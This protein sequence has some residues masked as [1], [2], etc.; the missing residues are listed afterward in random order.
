MDQSAGLTSGSASET[1]DGHATPPDPSVD[2]QFRRIDDD[3]IQLSHPPPRLKAAAA[4]DA[5]RESRPPGGLING[6]KYKR[7]NI[8]WHRDS[9]ASAPTR[10]ESDPQLQQQRPHADALAT[11]DQHPTWPSQDPEPSSSSRASSFSVDRAATAQRLATGFV[12]TRPSPRLPQSSPPRPPIAGS[13]TSAAAVGSSYL[14]PPSGPSWSSA[15][16]AATTTTRPI[17]EPSSSTSTLPYPTRR[18]TTGTSISTALPTRALQPQRTLS[19]GPVTS[20]PPHLV[21]NV[22]HEFQT[23]GGLGG[24]DAFQDSIAKQ[25]HAIRKEREAKKKERARSGSAA[26]VADGVL[27]GNLVGEDHVNYVLMYNMLTGIR[28]GVRF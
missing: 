13:S 27:V 14:Q 16:A 3:A 28:I 19:H 25:A 11:L 7:D 5:R 23:D 4:A 8:D 24:D 18:N 15:A 17:S 26:G 10:P 6:L 1:T 9:P 2:A 21:E 20:L 12:V 22:S